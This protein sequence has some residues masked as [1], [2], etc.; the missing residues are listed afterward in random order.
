VQRQIYSVASVSR[1]R[2]K[3]RSFIRD[4]I[5]REK[6]RNNN[7]D[8]HNH[9]FGII[10]ITRSIQM[11]YWGIRARYSKNLPEKYSSINPRRIITAGTLLMA[12]T[13]FLAYTAVAF[14][15]FWMSDRNKYRLQFL[16]RFLKE[17]VYIESYMY[18]DDGEREPEEVIR[19]I[20]LWIA[21]NCLC[22]LHT[23]QASACS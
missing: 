4:L 17:P 20:L 8:Q 12:L 5:R 19:K 1:L 21:H 10:A 15:G 11:I 14:L 22:S 9:I 6:P 3:N 7:I 13:L 23:L 18:N 2:I 16:Q